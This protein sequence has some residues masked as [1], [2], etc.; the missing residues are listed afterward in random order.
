MYAPPPS[1]RDHAHSL[2]SNGP[3]NDDRRW[4]LRLRRHSA[5]TARNARSFLERYGIFASGETVLLLR[6]DAFVAAEPLDDSGWRA[7]MKAHGE[8][9]FVADKKMR[10]DWETVLERTVAVIARPVVDVQSGMLGG[11]DIEA[12]DLDAGT[13]VPAAALA[14]TGVAT[15]VGGSEAT[16][17]TETAALP[18]PVLLT[19]FHGKASAATPV[20]LEVRSATR[21]KSMAERTRI[22]RLGRPTTAVLIHRRFTRLV[23]RPDS[24]RLDMYLQKGAARRAWRVG[25]R[26][27]LCVHDRHGRKHQRR[28]RWHL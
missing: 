10:N 27:L 8:E 25:A 9:M 5:P 16:A 4:A 6:R 15:S 24:T 26:R 28:D 23:V 2:V 7:M 3:H 17:V 22:Y 19:A 11:G 1:F 21:L 13:V 20:F 12:F 14:K 18:A